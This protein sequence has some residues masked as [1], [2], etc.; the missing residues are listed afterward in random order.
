MTLW[1]GPPGGGIFGSPNPTVNP[2]D[3]SANVPDSPYWGEFKGTVPVAAELANLLETVKRD[4]G[5]SDAEI[6]AMLRTYFEEQE[7]EEAVAA[8][9]ADENKRQAD[10]IRSIMQQMQRM[11]QS[12]MPPQQFPGVPPSWW[13]EPLAANLTQPICT[14]PDLTLYT[15]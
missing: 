14:V 15:R 8:L 9:A 11:Q 3:W 2:G 1:N 7:R 4:L 13:S 10:E 5:K 6:G 12:R